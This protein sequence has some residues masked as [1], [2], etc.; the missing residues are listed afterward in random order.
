MSVSAA[1]ERMVSRLLTIGPL[2]SPEEV[3]AAAVAA[4]TRSTRS[5]GVNTSLSNNALSLSAVPLASGD[6]AVFEN[7]MRCESVANLLYAYASLWAIN[8]TSCEGT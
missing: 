1:I 2:R 5:T 8:V 6:A 7:L 4:T 3:T